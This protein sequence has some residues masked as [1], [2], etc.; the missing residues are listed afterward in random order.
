MTAA[1]KARLRAQQAHKRGAA[2]RVTRRLCDGQRIYIGGAG[3]AMHDD[4]V[5][6]LGHQFYEDLPLP[7]G[8]WGRRP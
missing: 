2:R 3:V 7:I 6:A 4:I 1:R 5:D 8:A